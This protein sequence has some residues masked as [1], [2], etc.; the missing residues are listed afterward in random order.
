VSRTVLRETQGEIPWVY[1]PRF[2]YRRQFALL[3]ANYTKLQMGDFMASR[4]C[5]QFLL[6]TLDYGVR[7]G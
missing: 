4:R 3:S 6:F 2:G 7:S 1:S 5:V